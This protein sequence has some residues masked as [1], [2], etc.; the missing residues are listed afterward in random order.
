[1]KDMTTMTRQLV[2]R[3]GPILADRVAAKIGDAE[4]DLEISSRELELAALAEAQ[5]KEAYA[6]L[7][8]LTSRIKNLA[9]L[10]RDEVISLER[11][12]R[13]AAEKK[14]KLKETREAAHKELASVCRAREQL[15]QIGFYHP[16]V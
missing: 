2:V 4:H 11:I 6:E 15:K 8:G 3:E 12:W 1:M 7:R 5:A 16:S 14:L 10:L 13:S 9:P